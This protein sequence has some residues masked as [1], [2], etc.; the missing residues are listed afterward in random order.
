MASYNGNLVVGTTGSVIG[1]AEV[2]S[3]NGSS[4]TKLG[5]DGLDS[6]WNTNYSAAKSLAVNAGILYAGVGSTGNNGS[7]WKYESGSWTKIGGD[8][9]NSSWNNVFRYVTSMN[10]YNGELVAGGTGSTGAS[11]EVWKWSG[12]TWTKIGGDGAGSSWNTATYLEVNALA[13]YQGK[14][15]AGV[16]GSAGDGEAWEYDGSTWTKI[17]GDSVDGSWDGITHR[18]VA[19]LAVYNGDLYVGTSGSAGDGDAWKYDGSTWSQAGGDSISGGWTNAIISVRSMVVYKGKLYTG[20][21]DSISLHP[22]VYSLGNNGYLESATSSY[23]TDWRHLAATY[24]GTTMKLYINGQLDASGAVVLSM[25]DTTAPLL[26]GAGQGSPR[27]DAPNGI[28]AGSLDEVRISNTA[29]LS[30]TTKPYTSSTQG[31]VLGSAVRQSGVASWESL[32]ASETTDGGTI[33]YQL[34]DDGGTTWKYWSGSAWL[35]AT[36]AADANAISVTNANIGTFPVTFGGITWK[37][38]LTGNGDQQVTLNSVTLGANSDVTAPEANA[39]SIAGYKS[40]GGASVADNAWTN[41]GSPYFSWTAGN[42]SGAG[43]LGYCLYLGQDNTA[44]PVSTKGL[45]GTSPVTTGSHCQ[46]VVSGTTIDLATSGYLQTALSSSNTPYYLRVKAIDKAGNTADTATQFSF[47][48]DNTVPTNPSYITSPSG[49]I[50][51][52]Q[53]TLTWPTAGGQAASDA[54][55]GLAGLQYR[56]NNGT[57]YGDSHSGSGDVNDLLTNDGS[58]DTTDPPDFTDLVDGVNT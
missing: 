50:N 44:D 5:G 39:T 49:F 33:T 52:K 20:L 10:F 24:D 13:T 45:L 29:R 12:S 58:Y 46:F 28:L 48:F 57:W 32:A 36:T 15:I 18:R 17:G 34:S 40:S 25:N 53:A 4:W 30:F 27:A 56:I 11:A 55:A 16:G 31:V 43:L 6:S 23:N 8:G 1:D 7:V 3:W 26:V 35:T 51:T 14:L 37:A 54:N 21:G 2:W 9:A 19:S 22:L 38:L 41:G 42:D 47:R